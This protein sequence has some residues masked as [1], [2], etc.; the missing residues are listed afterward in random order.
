MESKREDSFIIEEYKCLRIEIDNSIK[1]TRKIIYWNIVGIAIVWSFLFSKNLEFNIYI[2][3]IP[4]VISLLSAFYTFSLR[5]DMKKIGDYIIKIEIE[6]LNNTDLGWEKNLRKNKIGWISSSDIWE[7][8]FW[9]VLFL[10]NTIG[11]LIF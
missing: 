5:R 9:I 4:L 7:N 8:V 10:V 3:W 6:F 11:A 1:H 2:K